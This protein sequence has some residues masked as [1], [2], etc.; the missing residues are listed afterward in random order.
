ML[1][2]GD[3]LSLGAANCLVLMAPTAPQVLWHRVEAGTAKRMTPSN[4]GEAQT[5][6]DE[7]AVALD[8]FGHVVAA[9]G[10]EPTRTRK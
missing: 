6:S 5:N 1:G 2:R 7:S 3:D 9:G 8:G 4:P 10:K